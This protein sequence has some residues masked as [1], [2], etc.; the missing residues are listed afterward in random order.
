MTLISPANNI[1]VAETNLALTWS[2]EKDAVQYHLQ[3]STDIEFKHVIIDQF[4]IK[5]DVLLQNKLKPNHYFWR[6]T[7]IDEQGNKG[8]HSD[9]NQFT[10]TDDSYDFLL[11]LLYLL[12]A[13]LL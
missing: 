5:Q 11:L 3:I 9:T 12:P 6:V 4:E 7:A 1:E 2:K 8:K 10:V 13:L